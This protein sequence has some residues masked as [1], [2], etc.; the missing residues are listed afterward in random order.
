[1]MASAVDVLAGKSVKTE[2]NTMFDALMDPPN[3]ATPVP[4]DQIIAEGMFIFIAGT[5]TTAM[6][7]TYATYY[8]LRDPLVR[9]KLLEELDTVVPDAGGQIGLAALESLPYLVCFIHPIGEARNRLMW[10]DPVRR[11]KRIPPPFNH[12]PWEAPTHHPKGGRLHPLH[13]PLH[14]SRHHHQRQPL[15]GPSQPPSLSATEGVPSRAMDRQR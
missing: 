9:A 6:A 13:K 3:G 8:V 4:R 11:D 1:M 14:S 15:Y 5:E 2:S 12:C 7:L 10:N